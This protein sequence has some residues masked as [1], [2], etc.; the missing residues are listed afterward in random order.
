MVP[1]FYVFSF[2]FLKRK[3]NKRKEK[4]NNKKETKINEKRNVSLLDL[5]RSTPT[6]LTSSL[7]SLIFLDV[8]L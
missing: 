7:N 5:F 8:S 3:V 2:Y 1:N 6:I 4:I